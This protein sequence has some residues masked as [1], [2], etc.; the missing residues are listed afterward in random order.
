MND[1]IFL[2][3]RPRQ[4]LSWLG[5]HPQRKKLTFA[6]RQLLFLFDALATWQAPSNGGRIVVQTASDTC[7][8]LGCSR[9]TYLRWRE[10]L[11]KAGMIT[12]EHRMRAG[13]ADTPRIHI[14]VPLELDDSSAR[15]VTVKPCRIMGPADA[16]RGGDGGASYS[17]TIQCDAELKA[18][19]ETLT[20]LLSSGTPEHERAIKEVNAQ[21]NRLAAGE[22]AVFRSVIDALPPEQT[23]PGTPL[24]CA[25]RRLDL[26]SRAFSDR[27]VR[28]HRALHGSNGKQG[29][30]AVERHVME[31]RQA[32]EIERWAHKHF[33]RSPDLTDR[34]KQ[35]AFSSTVGVLRDRP[36]GAS[37]AII[38][39]LVASERWK[40]PYGYAP[41]LVQ[42][43][44]GRIEIHLPP[45]HAWRSGASGVKHRGAH[46]V[47]QL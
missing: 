41:E 24:W 11:E 46:A 15:M 17:V 18:A 42:M 21:M 33:G 22:A 9:A 6:H 45:D 44:D 20:S 39:R 16:S 12:V 36:L 8:R 13:R 27:T 25:V 32:V 10:Q 35:A 38:R 29:V 5:D 28:G 34:I 1:E 14:H 23:D 26:A 4:I 30:S 37:L 19:R 3:Y 7:A 47:S 2:K 31:R 40:V 43:I